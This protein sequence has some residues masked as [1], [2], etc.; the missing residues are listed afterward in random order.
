MFPLTTLKEKKA[1]LEEAAANNYVLFFE[2]DAHMECCNLVQTEKG[3]R[4]KEAFQLSELG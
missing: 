2:H 4:M 1:F 3:T